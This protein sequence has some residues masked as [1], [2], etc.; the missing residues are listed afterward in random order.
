LGSEER[1]L[2]MTKEVTIKKRV[3]KETVSRERIRQIQE[4]AIGKLRKVMYAKG[5]KFED[6]FDDSKKK[7]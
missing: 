4:R 1:G 6:F 5:Y 3:F 7:G 2:A